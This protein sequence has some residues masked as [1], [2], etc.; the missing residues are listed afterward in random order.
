MSHKNKYKLTTF[1]DLKDDYSD[2]S[3]NYAIMTIAS[4][5]VIHI[6]SSY[7]AFVKTESLRLILGGLH[8]MMVST[9]GIY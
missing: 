6:Y 4:Y 3:F 9:F 7:S 8:K 2:S 5:G 1:Y